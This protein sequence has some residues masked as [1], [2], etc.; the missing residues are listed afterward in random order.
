MWVSLFFH[1]LAP[2]DVNVRH[3]K[4]GGQIPTEE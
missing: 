2:M 3:S 1:V 4:H